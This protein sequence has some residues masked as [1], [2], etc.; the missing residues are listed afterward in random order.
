MSLR[1]FIV[2]FLLC[3]IVCQTGQ[4]DWRRELEGINTQREVLFKELQPGFAI[5]PLSKQSTE[6]IG[7]KTYGINYLRTA[8]DREREIIY[9]SRKTQTRDTSRI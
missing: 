4:A 3:L 7:G 9:T 5:R 8:S 6:I 2:T 1:R